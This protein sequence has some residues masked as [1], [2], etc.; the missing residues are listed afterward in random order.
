MWDLFHGITWRNLSVA[1]QLVKWPINLIIL[2][3]LDLLNLTLN[4][5][6]LEEMLALERQVLRV[7]EFDLTYADPTIFLNYFLHLTCSED[8][9]LVGQEWAPL[10]NI[11]IVSTI[12]EFLASLNQNSDEGGFLV[13]YESFFCIFACP[14]NKG[15]GVCWILAGGSDG[16]EVAAAHPALPPGCGCSPL[17]YLRHSP[18]ILIH[19][20]PC[21][22]YFSIPNHTTHAQVFQVMNCPLLP[23][24]L[25]VTVFFTTT[26]N[27]VLHVKKYLIIMLKK[28]DL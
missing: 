24:S 11:F 4:S 10:L 22:L 9:T 13:L 15:G 7:L 17:C 1:L 14:L 5:Y 26:D 3:P 12:T 2:Q 8:D 16:G 20:R 19:A 28:D 23:S 6:T 27:G 25:G 18:C 21:L